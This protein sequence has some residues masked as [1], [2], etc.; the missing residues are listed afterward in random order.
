MPGS[1]IDRQVAAIEAP[2]QARHHHAHEKDA[3][4]QSG[5]MARG[6]KI[7]TTDTHHQEVADRRKAQSTL[8]VDETALAMRFGEGV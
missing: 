5:D 3:Q 1:S 7:E 2:E 4:A 8:T 6:A